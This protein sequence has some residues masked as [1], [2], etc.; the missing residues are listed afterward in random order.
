MLSKIFLAGAR[1]KKKQRVV[2]GSLACR[3]QEAVLH[4]AP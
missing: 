3:P 2:G 4:P 1:V